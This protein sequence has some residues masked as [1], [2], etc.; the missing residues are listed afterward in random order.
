MNRQVIRIALAFVLILG[1]TMLAL[2][3][4]SKQGRISGRVTDAQNYVV[5]QADVQ[6]IHLDTHTPTPQKTDTTGSFLVESLAAGRYQVTI[7]APGFVPYK[8]AA[9]TLAAGQEL[10]QNVQLRKS[11]NKD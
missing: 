9:I 6:V 2:A 3:Q 7:Q 8:S 5:Y 10:V 4:Q 11:G 1:L